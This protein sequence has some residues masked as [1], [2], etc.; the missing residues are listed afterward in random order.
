M[1]TCIGLRTLAV[2]G[3]WGFAMGIS[4]VQA[5]PSEQWEGVV[6]DLERLE[7]TLQE[8]SVEK[9]R[10]IERLHRQVQEKEREI[11]SQ[12]ANIA[13]IAAESGDNRQ[14]LAVLR[15]ELACTQTV[16]LFWDSRADMLEQL[17]GQQRATLSELGEVIPTLRQLRERDNP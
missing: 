14:T 3:A 6:K 16:K 11:E 17:L 1:A 5:Q 2:M 15:N 10:D 8:Q 13:G 12:K 7:R 4:V 9:E